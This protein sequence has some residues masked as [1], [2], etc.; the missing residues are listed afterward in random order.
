MEAVLKSKYPPNHY[1]AS[2]T[3][4]VNSERPDKLFFNQIS[5]LPALK[6]VIEKSYVASA[7]IVSR[8]VPIKINNE[9]LFIPIELKDIIG[10]IEEAKEILQYDFDWDDEG[11]LATDEHTFGKAASFV[12]DYALHIFKIYSAILPPPYIDILRDGSVTVHWETANAS[13]LI[14]FKK[15]NNE[16][17]YY[18][19][20]R[21]DSKVPF[22]SAIELGKPVDKFLSLWMKSNLV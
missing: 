19:A 16:L 7:I 11:A 20:E 22:K 12:K 2:E 17:A 8:N 13:F 18:Y 1:T 3:I 6:S 10:Q 5:Y 9:T 14:I 4:Y 21:K 15:E